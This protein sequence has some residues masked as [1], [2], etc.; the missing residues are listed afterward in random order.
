MTTPGLR[1]RLR[2]LLL[3]PLRRAIPDPPPGAAVGYYDPTTR[4]P[5]LAVG[6]SRLQIPATPLTAAALGDLLI[7]DGTRW[8]VLPVGGD[9]DVLTADST[10]DLGVTWAAAGGGAAATEM[11][12]VDKRRFRWVAQAFLMQ[13]TPNLAGVGTVTQYTAAQGGAVKA[14]AA[15]GYAGF[16]LTNTTTPIAQARW[17]PVFRARFSTTST[18]QGG[19]AIGF[20]VSPNNPAQDPA[21]TQEH[22]IV[23]WYEGTDTYWTASSRGSSGQTTTASAVT[24]ASSTEYEVEIRMTASSVAFYINGTLFATHSTAGNIPQSTTALGIT[25]GVV[26]SPTGAPSTGNVEIAASTASLEVL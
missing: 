24:P 14:A 18:L 21:S 15:S 3:W 2:D 8:G 19:Y 25:M 20:W 13:G 6:E 11:M 16:R 26:R 12:S 7:H 9:D 22:A 10:A 1:G 23:R 17:E 4:L 5:V